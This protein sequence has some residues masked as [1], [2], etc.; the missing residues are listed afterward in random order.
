MSTRIQDNDG[1]L[2][3]LVLDQEEINTRTDAPIEFNTEAE[4]LA[5]VDR[6]MATADGREQ[7]RRLAAELGWP[8]P[9]KQ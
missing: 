5:F 6:L 8:D 4:A 9:A 1:N 2:F 7:L 3:D